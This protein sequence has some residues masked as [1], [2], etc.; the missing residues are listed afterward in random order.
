[1]KQKFSYDVVR[2]FTQLVVV[3]CWQGLLAI[4]KGCLVCGFVA[5]RFQK[6]RNKKVVYKKQE[7]LFM[8]YLTV[9]SNWEQAIS[10]LN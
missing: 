5:K 7:L 1:M 6:N 4:G 8:K 3:G 2:L 10:W 9:A